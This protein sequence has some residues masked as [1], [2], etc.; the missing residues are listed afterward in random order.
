MLSVT[1]TELLTLAMIHLVCVKQSY[2]HVGF[3]LKLFDLQR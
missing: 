3:D 2:L 1:H